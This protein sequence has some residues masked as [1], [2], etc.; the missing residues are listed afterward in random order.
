MIKTNIMKRNILLITALFALI[1][2]ASAQDSIIKGVFEEFVEN[3]ISSVQKAV[4]ITEEQA[5]ALKRVELDYLLGVNDAENCFLCR[6]KRRIRKL[7]SKKEDQLKEI[8]SRDEYIKY[9]AFMNKKIKK[10]PIYMND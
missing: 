7:K 4:P 5:I 6:T 10:H 8:L 2:N 1:I 9:D 3:K